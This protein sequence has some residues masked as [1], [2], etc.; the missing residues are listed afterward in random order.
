[1]ATATHAD[2][3]KGNAEGFKKYLREDLTSG[4][5]VFLIA[6]PLCL[7]ISSASGFPPIAGIF[8]AIVGS[9]L[10]TLLSNS[11]L[12][13]K[14]PAAGLIVIVVGCVQQFGGDGMAGGF[15]AADVAAYRST[16]A[17]VAV[18]AL[19]QI[20]FGLFRGGILGEFFPLAAVHGMLAAIGIIIILK[21]L[22]VAVG[23]EARGEP[24]EILHH[25]PGTLL[26]ANPA[27]ALIGLVSLAIMFLWPIAGQ[28][29]GFFKKIPSPMIVLLVAVPLGM[30]FDLLHKHSYYL[31]GHEYQLSETYLVKMP[32]HAFGMFDDMTLPDFSALRHG[33]AWKWVALFA[34]IGSLES[35]LS[36]KAIDLLDPWRRKTNMNRDMTAV[37]VANLC[38]AMVGGLPMISEIVRSKANIMNG[39][40]TRFADFWHGMFL[41]LC[42]ALIPTLLHR[43]PTAALAA[44]LVYTGFR[45][46]HPTEFVHIY[47][48]GREQLI[49]FVTTIIAV[50]ATDL[51]IGICIG[52]L[53]KFFMHVMNGVPLSSLFKPYLE[54]EPQGENNCLIRAHQSAVFS[55][56][57]P[58]RRQLEDIGFV[59]R[60][61]I[62]LDLSHTKVVDHNVMSK[63]S[64]LQSEFEQEG[65]SLSIVGLDT[66]L[67]AAAHEL[68]TRKQS[69]VRM[70]RL[71]VVAPA[72]IDEEIARELDVCGV[73]D[74][75]IIPC[76]ASVRRNG[77]GLASRSSR[78]RIEVVAPP[79]VCDLVVARLRQEVLPRH[80]V[81]ICVDAVNA[82]GTE[83]LEN[84]R[85][86]EKQVHAGH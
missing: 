48:I 82:I 66:H 10:T 28:K 38:A 73:T 34:L 67:A 20:G 79:R 75:V 14:G 83:V 16:L 68:S 60:Q 5:L 9:V 41:L 54:I 62:T 81:T 22:P 11:E 1:M 33:F 40:R 70:Q 36:A 29:V 59:Q 72:E 6:L 57:I 24:L 49:I 25:L 51:L 2:V 47:R 64:E 52:I 80:R 86:W 30:A 56:W 27:I 4:F 44:M 32:D 85:T 13:I 35:L 74:C 65:L 12:T 69:L 21:Q 84:R 39:A 46:A 8:T 15:S 37:G 23:V 76:Q 18:A 53:L 58:F 78:I 45:L 26:S 61:N 31:Q 71:T 42:V 17:V 63:L 7:A 77:G 43:I 3:P 50:L 55:N 19:F